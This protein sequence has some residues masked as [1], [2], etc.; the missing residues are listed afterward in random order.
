MDEGA[1]QTS[2]SGASASV[3]CTSSSRGGCRSS[4]RSRGGR[5]VIAVPSVASILEGGGPFR[6]R[7]CWAHA[8]VVGAVLVVH[9]LTLWLLVQIMVGL[10]HLIMGA[11]ALVVL[12][13]ISVLVMLSAVPM[14]RLV[15]LV[16]L[17]SA[18]SKGRAPSRV[19][20]AHLLIEI[21]VMARAGRAGFLDGGTWIDATTAS[22]TSPPSPSA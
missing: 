19:G 16:M 20:I 11:I 10:G 22:V 4:G 3:A 14:L 15:V 2:V 17:R 5:F 13:L 7:W 1:V 9:V 18:L 12:V 6:T 21:G 8:I